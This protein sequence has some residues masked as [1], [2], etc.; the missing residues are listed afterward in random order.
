MTY[1]I[2]VMV[3]VVAIFGLIPLKAAAE[4]RFRNKLGLTIEGIAFLACAVFGGFL[5]A[6][7]L[8][9]IVVLGGGIA[10]GIGIRSIKGNEQRYLE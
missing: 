5:A 8:S 3:A 4:Y 10:V 2:W 1:L 7:T 6:T 9:S